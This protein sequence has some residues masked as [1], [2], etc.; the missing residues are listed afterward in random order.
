MTTTVH[1]TKDRCQCSISG[2]RQPA[3]LE[4][5][6]IGLERF[7]ELVLGSPE[8]QLLY[9]L[10]TGYAAEYLKAKLISASDR[11]RPDAA[12]VASRRLS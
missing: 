3:P 2:V 9:L 1:T 10:H 6:I 5:N 11:I 4:K 7:E 8:Q 12:A